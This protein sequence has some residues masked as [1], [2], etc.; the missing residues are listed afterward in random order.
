[1]AN[2]SES[3]AWWDGSHIHMEEPCDNQWDGLEPEGD[4]ES[5]HVLEIPRKSGCH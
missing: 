3:H 2:I 1:M 5:A 4:D